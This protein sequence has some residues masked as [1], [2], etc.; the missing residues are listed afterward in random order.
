MDYFIRIDKLSLFHKYYM[1]LDHNEY[2]ADAIFR[3]NKLRLKFTKEYKR[4]NYPYRMIV[5]RC[6]KDQAELFERACN[7]IPRIMLIRGRK[8]YA[9]AARQIF[10]KFD[11]EVSENDMGSLSERKIQK[12]VCK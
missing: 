8:D 11:K 9:E 1:Y 3:Q 7:D 12:D 4:K 2:Y 5:V 6:P 10:S